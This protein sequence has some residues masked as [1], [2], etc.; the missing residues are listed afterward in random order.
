MGRHRTWEDIGHGKK[1]LRIV[2]R[3]LVV[4]VSNE[5]ANATVTKLGGEKGRCAN[6]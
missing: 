4:A 5:Q 1:S 6:C 2:D 3:R